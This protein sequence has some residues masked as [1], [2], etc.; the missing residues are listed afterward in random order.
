MRSGSAT[1]TA[2]PPVGAVWFVACR[3]S[4]VHGCLVVLAC[5]F[6]L[7]TGVVGATPAHAVPTAWTDRV[8]P[9]SA[10]GQQA[11]AD[12]V[13]IGVRGSGESPG[14]GPTVTRVRDGLASR[15]TKGTVRQ[16]WLEYPAS[17]PHTLANVPMQ[18]LLLDQPMPTTEYF[19]SAE[20]GAKNLA[21]V[22]ADSAN[23]CPAERTILA[24]YSQGA[25][26][27]TSALDA[28]PQAPSRLA[29]A[30]LIGNPSHY[31]GQSVRELSGSASQNAIGLGAML[32]LLREQARRGGETNRDQAVRNLIQTTINLYEGKIDT[33]AIR[34]AMVGQ[35]AEIPPGAYQATYSVC[36]SGD[37]VCDAGPSMAQ[38]MLQNTTLD[39]EISRTRP[40]HSGYTPQV[41]EATLAQAS[42]AIAELPPL[43][44]PAPSSS[45]SAP[46]GGRHPNGQ[47]PAPVTTTTVDRQWGLVLVAVGSALPLLVVAYLM[48]HRHGRGRGRSDVTD[49]SAEAS[50]EHARME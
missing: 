31:P 26:V 47:Q 6:S 9:S 8:Q 18:S 7:A 14:Y 48:G 25:Q 23:R 13:F 22:L 40:I 41:L 32:A 1:P 12:F 10:A 21:T 39:S 17:D 3:R 43:A 49:G 5:L 20:T 36:Q 19:T 38:V 28:V 2:P 4:A 50:P 42:V 29:A 30:I 33:A 11:C 46:D 37:L 24:G 27:I 34:A 15:W 45:A 16:L 35:Q 44:V